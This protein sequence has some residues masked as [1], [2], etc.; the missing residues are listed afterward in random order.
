MT[1]P[2]K[3]GTRTLGFCWAQWPGQMEFFRS[4]SLPI[5]CWPAGLMTRPSD[6]GT[7]SLVNCWEVM[8]VMAIEFGKKHLT[9][10]ICSPVVLRIRPSN[11]GALDFRTYFL[12]ISDF[13]K[14]IL[15]TPTHLFDSNMIIVW[16]INHSL[17]VLLF[18]LNEFLNKYLLI[19]IKRCVLFYSWCSG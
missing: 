12:M 6:F 15:T 19:S 1:R 5:M 10:M 2:S 13:I 11:S 8:L 3:S 9:R 18:K 4:R 7:R 17:R 16:I 14:N